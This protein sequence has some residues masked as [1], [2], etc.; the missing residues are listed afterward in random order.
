MSYNQTK[1]DAPNANADHWPG[2]GRGAANTSNNVSTSLGVQTILSPNLINDFKGGWLYTAQ[3][4]GVD[5]S[6]GFYTSPIINYN[7]GNYNDNY[8]LP[9]SRKQPVFSVSDTMTWTKGTHTL[10]FGGNWYREVNQVPGI[11][12]RG[13]PSSISVWTKTIRRATS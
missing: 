10:R 1:L 9:N 3:S 8:E 5:G 12:P 2:D 11:R 7:Y 6:E 13:T 4:F